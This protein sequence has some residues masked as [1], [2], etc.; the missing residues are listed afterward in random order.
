MI[1]VLAALIAL[2]NAPNYFG[3]SVVGGIY[4]GFLI[5]QIVNQFFT[6]I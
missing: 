6:F 5:A 4:V 1:P 2:A 3:A